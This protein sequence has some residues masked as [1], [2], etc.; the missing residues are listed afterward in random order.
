MGTQLGH[1]DERP[2]HRVFVDPFELGVY[3]VTRAEYEGFCER[4]R[5]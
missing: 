5:A 1:A 4:H 2:P 3:P